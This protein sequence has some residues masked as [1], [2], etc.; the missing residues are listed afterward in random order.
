MVA[1]KAIPAPEGGITIKPAEIGCWRGHMNAVAEYVYSAQSQ[2]AAVM[3]TN[4]NTES[5]DKTSPRC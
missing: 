2:R 1:E 3:G 5:F 4:K